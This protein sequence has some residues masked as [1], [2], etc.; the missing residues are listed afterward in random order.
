MYTWQHDCTICPQRETRVGIKRT[1]IFYNS[2]IVW[3]KI[4]KGWYDWKWTKM[5]LNNPHTTANFYLFIYFF[6]AA[7]TFWDKMESKAK[8]S[9]QYFLTLPTSTRSTRW[10]VTT[11]SAH[12]KPSQWK[13]FSIEAAK[14]YLSQSFGE[15]AS[16][17]L[18]NF[19]KIKK[20][21]I[22]IYMKKILICV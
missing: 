2:I 3:Q 22:Y 13:D 15:V 1:T 6:G 8:C 21:L 10:M 5:P 16:N 20:K 12:L 18:F 7:P 9:H 17:A 4:K 19:C 11:L 14:S